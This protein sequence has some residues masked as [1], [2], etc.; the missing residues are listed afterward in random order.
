MRKTEKQVYEVIMAEN[1]PK[2]MINTKPEIQDTWK[3][4]RMINACE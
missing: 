1:F 3:M 2:L 4:P